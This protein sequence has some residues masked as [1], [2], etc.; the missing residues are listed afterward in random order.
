[1]NKL[2][3]YLQQVCR[4]MGGPKALREHVRQE[5]REHLLDA[6]AQ[7]QATGLSE[8]A[9]LDRALAEFGTHETVRNELEATHGHRM[10]LAMVIDKAMEWKERT[11]KAKW[12]WAS[13]TYLMV[14]GIIV[15]EIMFCCFNM[16][17]IV[18]KI[19]KLKHDGYFIG[20]DQTRSLTTWMFDFV[21]GVGDFIDKWFWWLI[22]TPLVLWGL[23][24]W[25]ARSENK[26]FMRLSALNTVAMGLLLVVVIMSASLTIPVLLS[27]PA[28]GKMARPWV[29]EQLTRIETSLVAAEQAA[30]KADR[31]EMAKQFL[32]INKTLQSLTEGP[33]FSSWMQWGNQ[34]SVE[35][36]HKA[37]AETQAQIRTAM[38]NLSMKGDSILGKSIKDI[39]K[40]YE[41][42]RKAGKREERKE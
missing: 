21:F 34:V 11:M 2:E 14:V 17:Y 15:L 10:M 18:P 39:E 38:D 19:K 27:M 22:L 31:L 20:D 26:P 33:G 16:I 42:L 8:E 40:T 36:M 9:A 12:L 13:W 32:S 35:E 29:S 23:F 28:L 4:S 37:V 3:H 30:G 5:L 6:A 41:P 24:E 1:M 25:R 7:H